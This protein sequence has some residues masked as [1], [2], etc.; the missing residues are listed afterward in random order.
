VSAAQLRLLAARINALSTT[1]RN[2]YDLCRA[3]DYALAKLTATYGGHHVLFDV[4]VGGCDEVAVTVDNVD[5]PLLD[6][7]EPVVQQIAAILGI[8]LPNL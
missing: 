6:H 1:S 4:Q 2:E 3:S 7:D 5:Q 8:S